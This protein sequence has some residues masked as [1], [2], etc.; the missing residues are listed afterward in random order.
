M[1]R[2]SGAD[3]LQV[4]V[5][6]WT[7]FLAAGVAVWR[8][9]HL[10]MDVLA[11]FMPG[12]LRGGLRAAELVVLALLAGLTLV[13][14]AQYAWSIFLLEQKSSTAGIPM[15]IPH[16]GVPLGFALIALVAVW[17]AAQTLGARRSA[18]PRDGRPGAQP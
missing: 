18:R 4:F 8:G 12:R 7:T 14:S 2:S 6:V 10:R 5:M 15:W 16:A 11:R 17:R 1:P 3:E 13:L 9:N